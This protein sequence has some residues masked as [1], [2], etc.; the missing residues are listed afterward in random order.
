[1]KLIYIAGPYTA[2]TRWEQELRVR[3]AE[4]AMVDIA[5]AGAMPICPHTMC[6]FLDGVRDWNFWME[7]CVDTLD[8]VHKSG[9]A[10]L[11]L[12]DWKSSRGAQLEHELATLWGMTILDSLDHARRWIRE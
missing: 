12:P 5:R 4:Y 3:D 7:G 9:G 11:M 1:M 2:P 10:V 8:A 6:R